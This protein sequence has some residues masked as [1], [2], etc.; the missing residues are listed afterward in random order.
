MPSDRSPTMSNNNPPAKLLRTFP[1][2]LPGE[3]GG[4]P[5]KTIR[6][7]KLLAGFFA[8]EKYQFNFPWPDPDAAPITR[9][10]SSSS[11]VA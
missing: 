1:F 11:P 4:F 5:Y 2:K 3:N 10:N 9:A 7:G 8:I 6:C